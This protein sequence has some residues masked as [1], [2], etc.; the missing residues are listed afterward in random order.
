ML[1]LNFYLYFT[2]V[3][4]LPFFHRICVI[5]SINNRGFLAV[6]NYLITWHVLG[7]LRVYR[8]GEK[9]DFSGGDTRPIYKTKRPFWRPSSNWDIGQRYNGSPCY[10]NWW[11][12]KAIDKLNELIYNNSKLYP[13]LSGYCGQKIVTWDIYA[14]PYSVF[15]ESKHWT[16]K[17]LP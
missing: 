10:F 12:P 17:I 16:P 5:L 8:K 3:I 7:I 15:I 1:Q 2:L 4:W 11:S 13:R 9:R 14:L 6:H